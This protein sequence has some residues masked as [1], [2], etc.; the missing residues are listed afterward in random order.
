MVT[1]ESGSRGAVSRMVMSC[2]LPVDTWIKVGM[3]PRRSSNVCI[4]TAALVFRKVAQGKIDRD[5]SIVVESKGYRDLSSELGERHGDELIPAG[6][7]SYAM[8]PFVLV[9]DFPELVMGYLLEQLC[10]NRFPRIHRRS[11]PGHS[12]GN[13]KPEAISNRKILKS[14][15]CPYVS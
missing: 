6:E 11:S 1:T 14:S 10:E 5:R 13:Y 15:L 9:D 8:T 7:R 4:L 2:T 12:E 3:D